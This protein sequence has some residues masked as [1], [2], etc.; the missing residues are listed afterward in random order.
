MRRLLIAFGICLLASVSLAQDDQPEFDNEA[1]DKTAT[2][3]E[4]II[5]SAEASSPALETLRSTL[6]DYRGAALALQDANKERVATLQGQLDALGPV[7]EDGSA[8]PDDI[9]DR[10]KTLVTQ[11]AEASG[12]GLAALEAYQRADGMIGEIDTII[13]NRLTDQLF[14]LGSSPLNPKYWPAAIAD[15]SGF[16]ADIQGEISEARASDAQRVLR[17]QNLP[18]TLGFLIVGL[19]LLTRARSWLLRV[20]GLVPV[21]RSQA[22]S[23]SR[24]LLVSLT[25]LIVPLLGLSALVISAKTT[26]MVSLRGGLLLDSVP[27][28]GLSVFGAHWLGH[29]LFADEDSAP[30]FFALDSVETAMARRLTLFMGL[31][32][33]LSLL[34]TDIAGQADFAT[35]SHVVLSFPIVLIAGVLLFRIGALLDPKRFDAIVYEHVEKPLRD[36]LKVLIARATMALGV[37]AP[38]LATV[39]YFTASAA[40]VFPAILTLALLG[41]LM[42][43]HRLLTDLVRR[44]IQSG[45][46][47][48][49]TTSSMGAL[50][51]VFLGFVLLSASAPLFALIWGA[52]LT[53]LSEVWSLISDGFTLGDRRISV[54]D[55]LTFAIVFVVGYTITR[56]LQTTLRTSVLPNTK[57]DVGG[58]NAILTGTGYTGIF[59]SALAAITAGGIDLSSLAIVAG[60]LSV[61]IGFGLQAI[62]SN[63]VS[64]IILLV[65][66]PIKEGDW[67]EVGA[68]SG[69]VRKISVRS[70]EIQTFDRATVIV[71]NADFISGTV[72]NRTHSNMNGRVRIPIGV[73][74]DSDPREVEAILLDIAKVHPMIAVGTEPSVVFMGFGA[75]SMDFE[76]RCILRDVNYMLSVK[77]DINYQ[78]VDRF[79]K[80]GIE[81]PFAQRDINLRNLGELGQTIRTAVRGEE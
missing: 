48:E 19:V 30:K 55:F 5:E 62:V 13:R 34:L 74:Y 47:S 58:R 3:A 27:W 20:I 1:W 33:A 46:E 49:T 69:Y 75:D 7:P 41:T 21:G 26:G 60:A 23:E 64:G 43:L 59:L 70:T 72:T 42:I 54:T 71:P 61:G 25:R 29:T 24:L 81:I 79:R 4:G 51:S 63:F 56:V 67:I 80:A 32:L 73:S 15:I 37:M 38:L 39:G 76:I 65:E 40:F 12:P 17:K 31:A 52:R 2:R 11:L 78:I 53:D 6:V 36:R 68:Y 45:Q 44:L 22:K 8:E 9:A 77:S 10:R 57:L 35:E 50:T 66:R 28:M 18:F 14:T 16:F